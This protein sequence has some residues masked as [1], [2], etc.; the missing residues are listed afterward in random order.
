MDRRPAHPIA[1]GVPQPIVIDAHEMYGEHFDIPAPD[2]LVFISSFAGGEVFRG[3]CC[4]ARGAGRIFYFSPGDR[5]TRSITT[6]TSSGCIAN[7]VQWAAPG[8]GARAPCRAAPSRPRMVRARGRVSAARDAGDLRVGV[9]GLG[10]A[11][12][13]HIAAYDALPGARGGRDRRPRGAGPR[14]SSPRATAIEHRV[15][16]WEDLLDVDGLD[17]VSVAVPT[18]L[19]APIAIA[20]LE[21]GHPRPV[22][23]ADRARTGREADA[24]VAAARAADRVL[25]V[26]FNHRQRGDIQELKAV[27]D[28]GRLGHPYYAKAWWLRRTGIPT[29]GSWFTQAELAGGGPLVDIGVHVLDY[30]LF[31]LG[32]PEVVAVSASTYDLLA[33]R[34][35]RR[36]ARTPTRPARATTRRSTSRTCASVFMR[37][38]DGGTLL[39]EASWAAH[40]RDGDEFG[41][42]LYGTDG[43]AEL[44]VD[45]Y[46]P[47]SARCSVFADDGG[48]AAASDRAREGRPRP[49]GGRR[50]V[51][52]EGPRRRGA[53]HDGAGGGGTRAI[54]D[55]C[56][57]S[58]AEQREIR[59]DS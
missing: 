25:D 16:R 19:H 22:R 14:A 13:Q 49:P 5:T 42:T 7:A 45:D 6:P 32:N 10:W 44:I 28:A 29:L 12:Q 48:T 38:A 36:R 57:R 41:I 15:A 23:E 3:G 26:A 39:V 59:L 40:R 21:R 2:E 9:I 1:A 20:A 18:F 31:L 47:E 4:F 52:R 24:M 46:A 27:I 8:P 35:L 58:A 11:G 54:V 53:K 17:A 30:S 55:A 43:G 50:A 37:L 51:R 56:Y 34:R 33:H